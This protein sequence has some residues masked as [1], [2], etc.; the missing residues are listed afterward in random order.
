M[1]CLSLKTINWTD[2]KVLFFCHCC[3]CVFFLLS[4][5]RVKMNISQQDEIDHILLYVIKFKGNSFLCL[6]AKANITIAKHDENFRL[7]HCAF[8]KI[9]CPMYFVSKISLK[10]FTTC[11][12]NVS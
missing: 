6:L 12:L 3:H 8:E 7:N 4:N 10:R 5:E 2:Q 11:Q 9:S 1:K